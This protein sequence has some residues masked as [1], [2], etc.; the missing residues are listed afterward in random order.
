MKVA[1]VTD[2]FI[3]D[4]LGIAW[5][6]SYLKEGGHEVSL[7]KPN[8]GNVPIDADMLCYSITT[9]KHTY[10]R[11]VNLA[12]KAKNPGFISVFGGPHVTF[13]PEFA[14]EP[15]VDV[16]VRG[17]GFD[18]IVE[19]ANAVEKGDDYRSIL[20]VVGDKRITAVRAS[21]D[22]STL[23]LPDR[24]L[25]YSDPENRDN[26]IKNVM[27][28]FY[29]PYNCKFCF[30]PAY[31]KLYG[32]LRSEIRPVNAVAEEI[33]QLRYYP[34]ELIFFNDDIF[35]VYDSEWLG[36]FCDYY[37]KVQVPFH[38]QLRVEYI[39]DAVISRL[40]EVGLHGVTF[41]IES[42][43]A[44]I[45]KSIGKSFPNE[46]STE[47]AELLHKY[48]VKLRT[49]NMIGVPGESWETAMETLA[50]NTDCNPTIGW[51]SLFQPYPGTE[52][53]DK[54]VQEGLFDGDLDS[55][56]ESF[57]DTYRLKVP[58]AKKFEKLQKLFSLMVKYPRL[59]FLLPLLVR[60]PFR[61]KRL[62][63]TIKKR[64]YKQLYKVAYN[65]TTAL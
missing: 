10:Y 26:P 31:K 11:D 17:E 5:L 54:C 65:E 59:Q 8:S 52:L 61:Y 62:Y 36:E 51:A 24:E 46:R 18:A 50:V 14:K 43:N 63:S 21:K 19:I 35:P 49:E 13:F 48:G 58:E 64:L 15:G 20:N 2:K 6:S 53:G 27:A 47:A 29:C 22:K 32:L 1:F 56:S 4:P 45:R 34:L 42:G 3:I 12:L 57:F 44:K 25:I 9:G 60:L 38:I 41:A 33:D 37:S 28:S 39:S 23:L 55:I 16:A 30:N 40:R 7:H